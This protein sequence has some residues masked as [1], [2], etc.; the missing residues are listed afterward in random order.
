MLSV[1]H[2]LHPVIIHIRTKALLLHLLDITTDSALQTWQG[3]LLSRSKAMDMSRL[4]QLLADP[5]LPQSHSLALKD[6]A[7][8]T[9]APFM[10]NNSIRCTFNDN[11]NSSIR[12]NRLRPI[13]RHQKQRKFSDLLI[14][15]LKLMLLP[16]FL[17]SAKVRHT[18]T[19]KVLE[20]PW[21]KLLLS[22][23]RPFIIERVHLDCLLRPV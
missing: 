12:S 3:L 11:N 22:R 6:L 8:R 17:S 4:S 7:D 15:L 16:A 10:N 1:D 13:P 14:F 21:P 5:L 19:T 20:R 9:S 2:L 18:F 23:V